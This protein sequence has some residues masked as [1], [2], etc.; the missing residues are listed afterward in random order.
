MDR[1]QLV[2]GASRVYLTERYQPPETSSFLGFCQSVEHFGVKPVVISSMA[3]SQG[4]ISRAPVG[5][6]RAQNSQSRQGLARTGGSTERSIPYMGQLSM[7][8]VQ[9]G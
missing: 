3:S 1:I 7:H 2:A 6:S 5:Q 9:L 8:N 4:V